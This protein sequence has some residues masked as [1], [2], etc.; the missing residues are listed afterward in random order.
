MHLLELD[1]KAQRDMFLLAYSGVKGRTMANKL[2]FE[3][4]SYWAVKDPEYENLSN[5]VS[6]RV[7]QLRMGMDR[8]PF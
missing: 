3:L 7:Q 2:L 5:Y 8:P 6:H 1:C 4:L